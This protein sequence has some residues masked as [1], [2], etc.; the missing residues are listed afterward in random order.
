MSDPRLD[1]LARRLEAL[2]PE[3]WDRPAPPRRRGRRRPR[4]PAADAAELGRR[5]APA[6]PRP[7]RSRRGPPRRRRFALRPLTAALLA[8]ALLAIGIAVA[9][10]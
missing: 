9:S 2:P 10:S 8:V 1:E 4:R 5:P 7:A 6:P 3:A